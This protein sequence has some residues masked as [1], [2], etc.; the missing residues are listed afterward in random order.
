MKTARLSPDSNSHQPEIR[1][2]G[3][4]SYGTATDYGRFM[5]MLLAEGTFDGARILVR[6][7]TVKL[8]VH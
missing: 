7:D 5:S 6:L 3:T 1:L 4:S 2:A 8:G